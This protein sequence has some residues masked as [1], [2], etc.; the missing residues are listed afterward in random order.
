MVLTQIYQKLS[1]N[2][3]EVDG[4]EKGNPIKLFIHTYPAKI[5]QTCLIQTG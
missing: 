3:K 2:K 5:F 4:H 1:R